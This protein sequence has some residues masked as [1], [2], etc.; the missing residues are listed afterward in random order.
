MSN[1]FEDIVKKFGI[2]ISTEK[3]DRTRICLACGRMFTAAER[4]NKPFCNGYC[5]DRYTSGKQRQLNPDKVVSHQNTSREPEKPFVRPNYHEYIKSAEWK[6]R[7]DAAKTRA[8]HACQVCNERNCQLE[9]HHR[10]YARLGRELPD[11]LTVLC[12]DCHEIFSK[13]G[14]LAKEHD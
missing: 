8:G 14:R 3:I 12:N 4:S 5:E 9:A 11:D 13:N 6:A 2:P 1:S 10:T 7:A